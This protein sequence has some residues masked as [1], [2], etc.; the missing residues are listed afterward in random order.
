MHVCTLALGLLGLQ[1][2]GTSSPLLKIRQPS[3]SA[4][5]VFPDRI[6]RFTQEMGSTLSLL[7]SQHEG[8]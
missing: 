3:S 1:G 8:L 7:P 6:L 5:P 4:L 2:Q